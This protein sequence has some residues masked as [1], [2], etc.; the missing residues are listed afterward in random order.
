MHIGV[1]CRGRAD[2]PNVQ[3]Q[4]RELIM[5]TKKGSKTSKKST[6]KKSTGKEIREKSY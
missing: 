5:A 4:L 6:A 3:K 1:E 2:T